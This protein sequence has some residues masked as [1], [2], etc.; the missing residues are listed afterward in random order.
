MLGP[1]SLGIV[2][3][4][5]N[6]GEMELNAGELE[7]LNLAIQEE[8]LDTGLAMMSSTRLRGVFS[9]RLA[10]M[11]YRST[12]EDVMATLHAI[13]SIGGRMTEGRTHK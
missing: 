11:N 8:I 5:F 10:I 13:E 9:L 4:R 7:A 12:R 2:C 3:F 6:P 1:A